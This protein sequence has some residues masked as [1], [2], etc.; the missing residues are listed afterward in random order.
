MPQGWLN[1]FPSPTPLQTVLPLQS[2]LPEMSESTGWSR[3]RSLGY[4]KNSNPPKA[5]AGATKFWRLP[6]RLVNLPG[7]VPHPTPDNVQSGFTLFMPIP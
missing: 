4:R 5:S 3:V 7:Q 1:C 2:I 6:A